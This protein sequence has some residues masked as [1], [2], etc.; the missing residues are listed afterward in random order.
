M[1]FQS[2]DIAIIGGGILGLATAMRLRQDFPQ[3]KV[4]VL[5]KEAE[6]AQHQ[7]GHNSGVIHAGI[8]YAPGSQKANFCST[9][10]K[11]LRQFCDERGIEYEMCG[12]V[13][14]AT[15]EEEIPRLEEL[16]RRGTA[17]GAEGLEMV[18]KERLKEL[19][20]HAAGVKA[21]F[22][23]NT[24][25]IDYKK[26]SHAYATEMR[27]SGG[28]L[29]TGTEVRSITRRD[30]R[31]YMETSKG[32]ISAR[33][34]I[35]CAGLHADSVARM[36]GVDIGVRIIPFRGEYYSIRP[37]RSY[38]VKS[39]IYP[40]PDPRLPFL[41]VHFTKRIGGSVEAGPNAVL[42]FA[43][44]GYKKT[45]FRF[46]DTLGTLRYPGFWRMAKTHWK[47]G[48]SEQY[49]SMMKG[50]FLKS[51]QTLVPEIEMSDLTQPG[52]GVR[53]QAVDRQGRL[54]QDFSIAET[55]S[56]IHVL[57]APSPG[58]TSSLTI[59]QYIVDHARKSFELVA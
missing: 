50:R 42:A 17:N 9:G 43:R 15:T 36:M 51:L 2:Y 30:G 39:L 45:S 37:E 56:A 55:E 59:S 38:L 16:F 53:A 29:L 4:A 47:T 22:S 40:V 7:T 12:K 20:P 19:E 33:F 52:A 44:E 57:N 21:I 23:P 11:L 8:Y 27:E 6:I 54:L 49:R 31:I 3:H 48:F 35:N 26:V 34:I 13:I 32:D 24:G 28:D 14:V 18:G 46:G 58:A 25:I 1:S 5:E 10:G 41:G